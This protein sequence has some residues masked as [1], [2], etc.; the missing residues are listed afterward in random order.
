MGS[1]L[2]SP[3]PFSDMWDGYLQFY[4]SIQDGHIA[5][6]WAQ[7]NEHRILISRL[8]FWVDLAWFNGQNW[9]LILINYVLAGL[10][11]FTFWQ[12]LK[13]R[14]QDTQDHHARI[15]IGLFLT[16]WMF[17]WTQN[18]NF[19]WGF[20]SQFL[21]AQLLPLCAFY[22]LYQSIAAQY[23][24]FRHFMMACAFGVASV[25]A[26][27]NGVLALPLMVLYAILTRQSLARIGVL[28]LLSITMLG[29]I[30]PRL[31]IT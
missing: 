5:E 21:L 14:S 26:M 18:D 27:A 8:L 31:S 11:A 4:M 13:I 2:I 30:F 19:T 1:R 7:H 15:L 16:A 29:T 24:S 20:Q 23:P 9:F 3:I 22:Y 25:G 28:V 12:L 10:S 6:W 17:L